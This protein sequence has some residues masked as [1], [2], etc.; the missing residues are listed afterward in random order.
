MTYS[1]SIKVPSSLLLFLLLL[2]LSKCV[3]M[4][5]L[6]CVYFISS[7]SSLSW[8]SQVL[9]N[10]ILY[11]RLPTRSFFKTCHLILFYQSLKKLLTIKHFFVGNETHSIFIWKRSICGNITEKKYYTDFFF[12]KEERDEKNQ[13]R[14]KQVSTLVNFHI[15][16]VV[17][18]FAFYTTLKL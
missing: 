16:C 12:G 5:F 15:S 7:S 14:K 13:S 8:L 3:K 9:K 6:C 4:C 2:N 1:L 11:V 17:Y 10:S 18:I